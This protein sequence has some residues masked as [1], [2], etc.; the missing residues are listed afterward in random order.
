M[1]EV[2]QD[3]GNWC[4]V[5]MYDFGFG[6]TS[7]ELKSLWLASNTLDKRMFDLVHEH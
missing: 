6:G 3:T 1:C 4:R 2:W 5:G 7:D